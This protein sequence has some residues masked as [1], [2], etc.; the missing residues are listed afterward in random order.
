[1]KAQSREIK[2]C[3]AAFYQS[4]LVRVLLGDVLHPGGLDLTRHLGEA[5]GLGP[6]DRVLDVACGRGASAIHLAQHFGCHVV[7]LDYGTDNV[8]AA[9]A[10]AAE[11]DVVHLTE[12]GPA[13]AEGIPCPG[14]TFDALISECSFCTFPDKG[15]VAVEMARVLGPG[16]RLGLTDVTVTG[17]LPHD[18]Q[19]L[20]AWVAC[21][22]GAGAPE[23]YVRTL[24]GAGFVGFTLEDQSDALWEMATDVRRKLLGFE[25]AAGLGQI[26]LEDIDWAEAQRTARRVVELIETQALGYTLIT[27][28]K[29]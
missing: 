6:G 9:R 10:R 2:V 26:D 7:G 24:Q 12:F 18:I 8:A 21:V 16:G 27:A 15:T 29:G 23:D 19:N 22:A 1:M 4:D 28:T 11:C 17:S 13:D 3:C 25:L 5:I 14:G 20:L